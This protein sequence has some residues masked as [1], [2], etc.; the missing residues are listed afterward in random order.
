MTDTPPRISVGLAVRNGVGIVGRCIDSVLSQDFEDLELV[1]SDNVS[2][3]GTAELL[4]RYAQADTRVNLGMNE[5]NIGS[6]ENMNRVFDRSRGTFFRWISADDWLEQ[7]CLSE[8]V[9]TLEEREDAIGAT[10]YFTI[11]SDGS[12]RY[13]EYQG[14]FPTSPDP[15]RRFE[16]MLWFFH[17]GDAKYDPIYGVYRRDV[18]L[19]SRRLRPSEQ[20]DWLLCAELALTGPILNVDRRLAHRTRS[21]PTRPDR[22]GFRRRLDPARARQLESSARRLYRDL[23]AL[24]DDADLSEA[25]RRRCRAALRRFWIR[26]VVARGRNRIATARHRVL[27]R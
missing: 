20:T 26:D 21:Y 16:R 3:D 13:E 6:H 8:C 27:T 11:H 5:V 1:I 9:R 19:R 18:L 7:S 2:D 22:A 24:V 12:S 25:Q 23:G 15:A 14:E 17:A 4:A 10:T